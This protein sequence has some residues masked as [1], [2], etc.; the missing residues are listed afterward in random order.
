[1]P[2]LIFRT[3]FH[4]GRI[5]VNQLGRT[6]VRPEQRKG[7]MKSCDLFLG[8]VYGRET[9]QIRY[10]IRLR[11]LPW[12]TFAALRRLGPAVHDPKS[13]QHARS[14]KQQRGSY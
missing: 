7:C 5:D 3:H 14:Q 2:I 8:T 13:D 1:M 4:G 10:L 9:T 12:L 11:F 6:E